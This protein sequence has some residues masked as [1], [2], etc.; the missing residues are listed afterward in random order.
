M[1]PYPYPCPTF[2]QTPPKSHSPPFSHAC[3][4]RRCLSFSL[5]RGHVSAGATPEL[6]PPLARSCL[7]RSCAR[8]PSLSLT[9]RGRASAR[10]TARCGASF[11]RPLCE[12]RRWRSGAAAEALTALPLLPPSANGL[13]VLRP[14][15]HAHLNGGKEPEQ[16][17]H[18]T[19]T[20][21]KQRPIRQ[22]V[23]PPT[24]RRCTWSTL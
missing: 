21:R 10:A 24:E 23:P 12:R 3:K 20:Q 19:N 14:L 11:S 7:G 13:R 22:S 15:V 18:C 4:R 8:R 9:S 2:I 16:S 1:F 17:T 5:S 6:L